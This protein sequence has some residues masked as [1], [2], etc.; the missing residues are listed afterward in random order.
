MRHV[1][2]DKTRVTSQRQLPTNHDYAGSPNGPIREY[3]NDHSSFN[4]LDLCSAYLAESECRIRKKFLYK[5]VDR[6]LHIRSLESRFE[7]EL[8]FAA[9]EEPK[10][11]RKT[12]ERPKAA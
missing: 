7:G 1:A 11:C 12:P 3:Q 6:S 9:T 2:C 5:A 4:F 10:S 8:L